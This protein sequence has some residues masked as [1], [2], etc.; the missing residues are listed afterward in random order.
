MHEQPAKLQAAMKRHGITITAEFVPWSQSRSAVKSPKLADYNLNW[1]VTLAKDGRE[2]VTTDYGA[3]Q[4]HCPSYKQGARWTSDYAASIKWECENGA[5]YMSWHST[6][7][8]DPILPDSA[9]VLASLLM[10]SG[11]LDSSNFEEWASDLGYDTDSRK[12]ESIYRACLEIALKMRNGLGESVLA[13]L[14]ESAQD[15]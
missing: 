6:T 15:Y 1:R 7:R 9:D 11:V 8:A 14:R 5:K 3:G 10:D 13:D 4:G 12:A 2:I